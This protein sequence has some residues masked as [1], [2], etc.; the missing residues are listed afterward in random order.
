[1]ENKM[2]ERIE[3]L[4]ANEQAFLY[5]L[6]KKDSLIF[7]YGGKL[8]TERQMDNRLKNGSF[9]I[10]GKCRWVYLEDSVWFLWA[11]KLIKSRRSRKM[12]NHDARKDLNDEKLRRHKFK[13]EYLFWKLDDFFWEAIEEYKEE[14]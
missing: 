8:L 2:L 11:I 10:R 12:Y 13:S 4:T 9:K 14:N 7:L 1:M 5:W 6:A 3:K